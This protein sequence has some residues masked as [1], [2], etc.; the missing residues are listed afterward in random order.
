MASEEKNLFSSNEN[1]QMSTLCRLHEMKIKKKKKKNCIKANCYGRNYFSQQCL[2]MFDISASI[3]GQNTNR[4][5]EEKLY[6][7][8]LMLNTQ[9][10]CI[11]GCMQCKFDD[12]CS[13]SISFIYSSVHTILLRFLLFCMETY[14]NMIRLVYIESHEFCA[15]YCK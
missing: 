11:N 7:Y 14:M 13:L 9:C 1:A 12:S 4:K 10:Y 15:I 6:I 8:V 3:H 2:L 5:K